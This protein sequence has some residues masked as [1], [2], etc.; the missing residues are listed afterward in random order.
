MTA[1]RFAVEPNSTLYMCG[2][3]GWDVR[4]VGSYRSLAH[5]TAGPVEAKRLEALLNGVAPVTLPFVALTSEERDRVV[6]ITR[7]IANPAYAD[8]D[9]DI[10]YLLRLVG[11]L[12]SGERHQSSDD[13]G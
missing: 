11:D 3:G 8:W 5:V 6:Q 13:V 2:H 10:D 12:T 9:A 4:R 7:K 1:D